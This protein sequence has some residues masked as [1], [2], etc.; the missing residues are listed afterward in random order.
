M[1]HIILSYIISYFKISKQDLCPKKVNTKSLGVSDL[2]ISWGNRCTTSPKT[3]CTKCWTWHQL[4]SRWWGLW[5][6]VLRISR[7]L[8]FEICE[9]HFVKCNIIKHY[10]LNQID[11]FD[12]TFL[13][14]SPLSFFR[15]RLAFW[16]LQPL[17]RWDVCWGSWIMPYWTRTGQKDPLKEDDHFVC[18]RWTTNLVI[19]SC[20]QFSSFPYLVYFLTT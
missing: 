18:P 19:Q 12:A 9:C 2:Q 4:L 13:G 7:F 17:Q 8:K 3:F 16:S 6:Q 10:R 1:H 15:W 20:R 11:R 5:S 14:R